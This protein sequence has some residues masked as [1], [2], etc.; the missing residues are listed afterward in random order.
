T[1]IRRHADATH[2]RVLLQRRPEELRVVVED[3]GRGL[4]DGHRAGVGLASMRERAAELGGVCVIGPAA[5]RGTRV[6]VRLP[7]PTGGD[8]GRVAELDRLDRR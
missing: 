5:E 3:D 1:N 4:P 7:L 2:A 8:E 6:E